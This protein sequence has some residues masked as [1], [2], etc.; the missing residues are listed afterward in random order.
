MPAIARFSCDSV[1]KKL[2]GKCEEKV[3]GKKCHAGP[4][5]SAWPAANS[6][7]TVMLARIL[8]EEVKDRPL[9]LCRERKGVQSQLLTGLQ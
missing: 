8:A 7:T 3:Y 9:A 4:A 5:I 2:T 1:E 6:S